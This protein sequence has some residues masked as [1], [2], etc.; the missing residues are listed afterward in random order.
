[1]VNVAAFSTGTRCGPARRGIAALLLTLAAASG[2]VCGAGPAAA[3]RATLVVEAG[4]G[5]V[6]H[7]ENANLRSFPASTTKLMTLYLTFEAL[8]KGELS[9]DED[10]PVSARAAGQGGQSLDLG[11]GTTVKARDAILGTLVESAN[12]AAVVLAERIA[13]SEDAFAE[14]MTAKAADLGMTRSRFRN[15]SGLNHPEQVVTAR[16]LAVLA[17]ALMRDF[18]DRYPLFATRGFRHR[19]VGYT[20]VNGFLANYPGADGL[21]TGF[22]C[23]AGYNLVASAVRDGRRLVAIVL[24]E[25]SRGERAETVADLMNAGF[26]KAAPPDAPTL[27]SIEPTAAAEP[28]PPA[29]GVIAA[30]CASIVAVAGAP[31]AGRPSGVIGWSVEVAGG[32]G[33]QAQATAAGRRVVGAESWLRGG[34]L[35]VLPVRGGGVLRWRPIVYGLMQRSAQGACVALRRK[36][37]YCRVLSPAIVSAAIEQAAMVS[38]ARRRAG[39]AA[40]GP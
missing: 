34:R 5:A 2:A 12:D 15:A 8:A 17:F 4:S 27:A 16:D 25:E 24:G 40:G 6:L 30:S 29:D 31:S 23:A 32:Y 21:K 11:V 20:T 13:G 1:M 33:S 19:G 3:A 22:T 38:R 39:S 26:A 36:R 18:P 7:V 10:L 9:L 28:D 35:A 14:R 37:T